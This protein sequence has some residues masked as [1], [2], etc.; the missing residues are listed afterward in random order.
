ML[1]QA[2]TSDIARDHFFKK[3]V[4]MKAWKD[5]MAGENELRVMAMLNTMGY[6]LE[7]DYQRQYPIAQR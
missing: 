7:R 6:E 1:K 5:S 3:Q 2:P 4:H